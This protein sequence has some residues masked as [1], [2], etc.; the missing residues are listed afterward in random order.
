MSPRRN[1]AAGRDDR[2]SALPD[3]LLHLVLRRLDARQA[4]RD[5]SRLSRRWRRLWASSPFVTLTR[6]G[7]REKFGNNLLLRR[8]P[9]A[10]LRVFCLHISYSNCF[11]QHEFQ[12]RWLRDAISRG[13]LRVLEL[14]FRC[15]HDF[16][17]PDCLFTCAT[18]EEMEINLSASVYRQDISP[19]SVCLP[20]LKKMHLENLLIHTSAVEKLNCGWPA[21]EDLNLHRCRLG[22]FKIS[23]ETLKT[24]SITD[25]THTEIK[26]SAPNT[27][28]LKLTF[29][30]RVHLSAMP[31]LVS[32]WVN[33]SDGPP[34]DHLAPACAYDL[35]AALSSAQRIE[36]FRFELLPQDIVQKAATE[37]LLV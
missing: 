28:S 29:S 14:T 10:P 9:A 5:L 31:R 11:G 27:A 23:S 37:G 30:G 16:E 21:L 32:A 36:L 2:L 6:S 34:G 8:D 19:K 33:V 1:A 35:V 17:L 15:S 20:R 18:L 24:L 26:V 7:Y 13:G 25:C 22:S 3:D 4:V 12:R